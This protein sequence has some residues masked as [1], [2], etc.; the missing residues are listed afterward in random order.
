MDEPDEKA[1]EVDDEGE[2]G[3]DRYGGLSDGPAALSLD[4]DRC[5]VWPLPSDGLE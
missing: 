4:L 1:D 3:G 5:D 2:L